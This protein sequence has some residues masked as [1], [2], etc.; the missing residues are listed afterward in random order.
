MANPQYDAFISYA[1]FDLAFSE[2][3]NRRLI[4]AGFRVWFDEARLN[5]GCEWHREIEAG[6]EASRVLLPC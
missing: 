6:C 5:P 1:S 4:E 3:A 2:E